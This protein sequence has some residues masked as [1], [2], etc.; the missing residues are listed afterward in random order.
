MS[1]LAVTTHPPA[2]NPKRLRQIGLT[3]FGLLITALF[4][5]PSI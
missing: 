2:A 1:A 5:F 4:C 3:V